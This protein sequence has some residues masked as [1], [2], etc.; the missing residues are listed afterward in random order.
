MD[1]RSVFLQEFKTYP[2]PNMPV[3]DFMHL[4]DRAYKIREDRRKAVEEGKVYHG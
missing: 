2:A 4:S 1:R 3:Y